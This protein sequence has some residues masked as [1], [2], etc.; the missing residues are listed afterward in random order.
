MVLTSYNQPPTTGNSFFMR[1]YTCIH[2]VT[3]ANENVAGD[4]VARTA[5]VDHAKKIRNS[6]CLSTFMSEATRHMG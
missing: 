1:I 6:F 2:A 5:Y 3:V 4:V